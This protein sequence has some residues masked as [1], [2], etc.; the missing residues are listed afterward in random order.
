MNQHFDLNLK[1][2]NAIKII[3][4]L[5]GYSQEYLSTRIGKSQNWLQKVECGEIVMTTRNLE[6]IAESLDVSPLF[7]ISFNLDDIL[8]DCTTGKENT[9]NIKPDLQ[10]INAVLVDILRLLQGI[11]AEEQQNL[12]K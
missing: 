8:T 10:A 1:I 12:R 2:A 9:K 4:L 3:R 6:A 5:K 7:I 11:Y